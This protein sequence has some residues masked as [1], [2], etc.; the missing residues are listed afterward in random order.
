MNARLLADAET[1]LP[2]LGKTL[3]AS[4]IAANPEFAALIESSIQKIASIL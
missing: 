3:D 4:E 2:L 1:T